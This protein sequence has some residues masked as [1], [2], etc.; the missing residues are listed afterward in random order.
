MEA[1]KA[2]SAARTA[3]EI[4]DHDYHHVRLDD[5]PHATPY[6]RSKTKPEVP[7]AKGGR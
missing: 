2:A 1:L 7:Q 5:E 3:H 6:F 4:Q